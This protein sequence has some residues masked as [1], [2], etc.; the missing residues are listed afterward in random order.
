MHLFASRTKAFKDDAV[1]QENVIIRLERDGRQGDVTVSHSTDA[2]FT[3][4]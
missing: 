4:L 3:D 1:L 2:G